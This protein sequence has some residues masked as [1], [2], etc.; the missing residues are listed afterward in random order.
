MSFVQAII[1]GIIQGLT[2]FLPVSSSGHLILF[3]KLFGLLDQGMAFDVVLHLGTLVAVIVYFRS[4]L[5]SIIKSY[6]SFIFPAKM[7]DQKLLTNP[8]FY[9]NQKEN[10]KLGN[11]ILLSIIPASIVGFFFGDWLE[12]SFRSV[13]VVAFSLIFWGIVLWIADVYARKEKNKKTLKQISWKQSLFIGCAQVLALIPGT[14]RS[15]ITMT[16]GLFSKF[17][18]T[19]AAEFSFLMSVPII[20][21]AGGKGLLDLIQSGSFSESF[22][23]LLVGFIFS[24]LSGLFAVWGLIKIIKKYSFLP[25]VIYRIFLGFIILFFI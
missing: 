11:L 16:A 4:K 24:A 22:L 5:W 9:K 3:P 21:L 14:S 13:K 10:R 15:G 6:L 23:I 25:F 17:N 1:L 2:E 20:A 7:E 12:N 18:K 19:S 8:H